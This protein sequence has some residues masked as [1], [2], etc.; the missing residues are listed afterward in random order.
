MSYCPKTLVAI[1]AYNE[2]ECI[3]NTI[4]ELRQVAP[5]F[6]FVVINDGSHDR[7]LSI[8]ENIA[9]ILL[10]CQLTVVLRLDFRPRLDM[11]SIM[12]MTI[13]FSLMLTGNIVLSIWMLLL[14][15]Q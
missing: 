1:P 2:E 14:R 3:E 4:I 9:A 7:T 13:W 10:T 11:L 15:K 6:D 8:C 12:D 5:R